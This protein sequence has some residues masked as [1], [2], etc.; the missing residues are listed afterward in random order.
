MQ[1][2]EN[3][4]TNNTFKPFIFHRDLSGDRFAHKSFVEDIYK[5]NSGMNLMLQI[6]FQSMLDQENEDVTPYLSDNQ[7]SD[8]LLTA[9][10]VNDLIEYRA[11]KLIDWQNDQDQKKGG[12]RE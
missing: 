1:H 11:E 7:I 12:D 8:I 5:I 10:G 4:M 2:K 6:V 3:T 9:I